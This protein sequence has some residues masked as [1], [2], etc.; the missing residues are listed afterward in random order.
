MLKIISGLH[1]MIDKQ[2]SWLPPL[3]A[4]RLLSLPPRFCFISLGKSLYWPSFFFFFFKSNEFILYVIAVIWGAKIRNNLLEA[5]RIF[6][7]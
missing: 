2:W 7:K 4:L 1:K 3:C 6:S 5:Q